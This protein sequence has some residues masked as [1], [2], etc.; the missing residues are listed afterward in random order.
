M[1][2]IMIMN[3]TVNVDSNFI[4]IYDNAIK[5]L[6]Y[7][8]Q[9][10][11]ASLDKAE[12]VVFSI[13]GFGDRIYT[14][15]DL[16]TLFVQAVILDP[17]IP[18]A[19]NCELT[20][21]E[22]CKPCSFVCASVLHLTFGNRDNPNN[23]SIDLP[24]ITG[25]DISIVKKEHSDAIYVNIIP[26]YNPFTFYGNLHDHSDFIFDTVYFNETEAY[27]GCIEEGHLVKKYKVFGFKV[28]Y[29]VIS[30]AASSEDSLSTNL[31][32]LTMSDIGNAILEEIETGRCNIPVF[33]IIANIYHF[34][35]S[36]QDTVSVTKIKSNRVT[37]AYDNIT[38]E[39]MFCILW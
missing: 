31:T 23:Y 16:S 4:D 14:C 2:N 10:Y 38:K 15:K 37:L 17:P 35:E 22:N 3:P 21:L 24:N 39:S 19:K 33:P 6:E 11:V 1:E 36:I 7:T 8:G 28:A 34:P 9:S 12:T 29:G 13:A 30:I 32:G 18:F 26:Y 20:N 27:I 5:T 25:V